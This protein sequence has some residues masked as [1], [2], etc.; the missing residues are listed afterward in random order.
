[1][2]V[3]KNNAKNYLLSYLQLIRVSTEMRKVFFFAGS[4]YFLA[5][6]A[7][8]SGAITAAAITHN[9]SPIQSLGLVLEMANPLKQWHLIF[10]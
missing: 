6:Q 7:G 8:V 2:F 9:Y 10:L 1:M 5:Q 3:W 4:R